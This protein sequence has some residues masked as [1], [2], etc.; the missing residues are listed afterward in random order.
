MSWGLSSR[1]MKRWIAPGAY[2]C[3][4]TWRSRWRSIS[5]SLVD[6]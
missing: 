6:S 4:N 3:P 5:R 2:F 1:V